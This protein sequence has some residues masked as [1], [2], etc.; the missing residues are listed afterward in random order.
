MHRGHP[1]R[2][3]GAAPPP[4][5][6]ASGLPS[7]DTHELGGD[8]VDDEEDDTRRGDVVLPLPLSP[9]GRA[10]DDGPPLALDRPCLRKSSFDALPLFLLIVAAA[11]A[12][13]LG[14]M[15]C[16]AH[17]ERSVRYVG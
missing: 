7:D 2:T 15:I 5:T 16:R 12:P 13:V 4:G 17:R 10:V 9:P 14:Q 3:M 6:A 11:A 8:V 1:A